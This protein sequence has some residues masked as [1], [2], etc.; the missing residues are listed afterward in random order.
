MD[1]T[2]SGLF[3][4]SG[5]GT[6]GVESTASATKESLLDVSSKFKKN[7]LLAS[8][9]LSVRPSVRIQQPGTHWADFRYVWYLGIFFF[10]SA[11]KIQVSLQSDKNN[12]YF[13]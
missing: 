3:P 5:F 12:R 8:S 13:T 10:K 4:V 9:C 11:E 6:S 1:R 2:G 7:R